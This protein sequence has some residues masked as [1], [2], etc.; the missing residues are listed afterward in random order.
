MGYV[1]TVIRTVVRSI[2][3]TVVRAASIVERFGLENN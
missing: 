2:V 1:R 3:R